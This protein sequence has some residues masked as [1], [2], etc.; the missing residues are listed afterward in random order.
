MIATRHDLA[1]LEI[2]W[3]MVDPGYHET[4]LAASLLNSGIDWLGSGRT[5]G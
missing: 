5:S 2:D 4:D 1:D 3:L